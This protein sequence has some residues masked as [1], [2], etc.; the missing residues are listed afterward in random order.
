MARIQRKFGAIMPLN[1]VL[2]VDPDIVSKH[3]INVVLATLGLGSSTYY[4]NKTQYKAIID[5]YKRV[6]VATILS[7]SKSA[8]VNVNETAASKVAQKILDFETRIAAINETNGAQQNKKFSLSELQIRWSVFP[9]KQYL[10]ILLQAPFDQPY[11]IVQKPNFLDSFINSVAN[12]TDN[13]TLANYLMW[14]LLQQLEEFMDANVRSEFLR[15]RWRFW[16][17]NLTKMITKC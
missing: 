12:E 1:S 15:F 5:Q 9:W 14:R 4:L 13:E 16:N 3:I 6:I 11:L 8:G 17:L 2:R 10:K 7:L